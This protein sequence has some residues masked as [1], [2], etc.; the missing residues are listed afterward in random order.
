VRGGSENCIMRNS[1]HVMLMFAKHGL[2]GFQIKENT[3]VG[4]V[5]RN[6]E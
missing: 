1:I 6:G 2:L 4:H 3:S 5:A